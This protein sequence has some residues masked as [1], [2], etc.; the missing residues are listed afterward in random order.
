MLTSSEIKIWKISHWLGRGLNPRPM[1]SWSCTLPAWPGRL[2]ARNLCI[3]SD[4]IMSAMKTSSEI[5]VW[6]ISHW[7]GRDSNPRPMSSWPCNLP[8]WPGRLTARSWCISSYI[9]MSAMKTSSEIK[10][11]KISHWL[12]RDLNP[13]SM[14][15]WHALYQCGHGVY[16]LVRSVFHD[17][18]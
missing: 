9:L 1:S 7:L 4:I 5:K 11:W 16:L 8:A 6:K 15:L 3:S 13:R 12:G 2:T 10:I 17:I 18:Y 14:S